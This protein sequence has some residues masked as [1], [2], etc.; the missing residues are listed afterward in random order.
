MHTTP[1]H[2]A[3][4]P[5]SVPLSLR[6]LNFFNGAAQL[7]WAVFGFGMI[8][9]WFFAAHAD[10]S[11]ATFHVDGETHG[12]ITSVEATGASE[13]EQRVY[14]H[15][16]EYSVAGQAFQGVSYSTGGNASVGEE[17]PVDYDEGSPRRSRIS[18][19]RRATFGPFA[20]IVMI[21][22]AIGFLI[23]YFST[24]SGIRRNELLREGILTTGTLIRREPTNMTVNKRR[25]WELTFEFIDR[26]GQRREAAARATDTTRLEDE[27]REP[28]L[29]DPQDPE[30][31]YVLDEAPARP[32]LEHGELVGRGVGAIAA[33]IL[34]GLVIAFNLFMAYT[35]F[36]K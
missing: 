29:Y 3:A 5:R 12:R 31:A 13:N 1:M 7:G 16:Y 35:K 30:K 26:N 19:M 33:L 9:A 32:R 21:F 34:P 24:K 23:L 11:F 20:A 27:Q 14:A 15:H 6:V 10:F 28:L 4:P 17:V 8:F 18:G 25:V 2:F 22:P 36:V